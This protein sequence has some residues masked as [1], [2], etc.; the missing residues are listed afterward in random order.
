MIDYRE[1]KFE[2]AIEH[3]LTHHGYTQA[4]S[5]NFDRALALDPTVLL[6][7]IRETQSAKWKIITDY[8]GKNAE[9][10]FLEEVTRAMDARGSLDVLRHGVDF[11]GKNFSLAF[12]RPAHRMNP[13][14]EKDYNANR[15]TLTRQ[16]YYSAEHNKSLD[17]GG[18]L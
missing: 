15:L 9:T 6:P 8:H 13:D 4:D 11:F 14:A 7:F 17:L 16:L 1:I 18:G 3:H 2:E 12:F 5:K 10:V